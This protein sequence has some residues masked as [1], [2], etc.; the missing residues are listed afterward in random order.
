MA[1]LDNHL[2]SFLFN[3]PSGNVT[4]DKGTVFTMIGG[5]FLQDPVGLGINGITFDGVSDRANIA[6]GSGN[7]PINLSNFQDATTRILFIVEALEA[8]TGTANS[9]INDKNG[10][11][12]GNLWGLTLSGTTASTPNVHTSHYNAGAVGFGSALV[13]SQLVHRLDSMDAANQTTYLDGGSADITLAEGAGTPSVTDPIAIA[14]RSNNTGPFVNITVYSVDFFSP[15]ISA[16]DRGEL[17]GGGGGGIK[18]L[19]GGQFL[20]ISPP[21]T[22]GVYGASKMAGYQ[23]IGRLT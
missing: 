2:E 6:G 13:V 18:I 5:D 3:V 23:A 8:G 16:A 17:W 1:L 12:G 20:P 19:K 14:R 15:E 9:V 22:G 4:G 11:A 10:N 21:P 7:N